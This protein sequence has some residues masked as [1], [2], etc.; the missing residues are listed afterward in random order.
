MSPNA[1]LF[2]AFAVPVVAL[3]QQ[4]ADNNALIER[5]DRLEQ[6]NRVMAEEIH[7]LRLEL[8]KRPPEPSPAPT[9]AEPEMAEQVAVNQQRIT[10]LAEV[11]V[12]AGQKFPVRLTGMALFNAFTNSAP[13][14]GAEN[15]VV[16]P[17]PP[18][19]VTDG[20]TMRQSIVGLEFSGPKMIAG[21]KLS[22]SLYMDFFG[23][24]SATLNHLVRLRTASIQMDWQNT[25]VMFGQQKPIFSPRDPTSLAQV[26]VSPLTAAG[27][28]W[29][30]LPQVRVEQRFSFGEQTQLRAQIGVVQTSEQSA[31][32]DP[33]YAS[34]L[35]PARPA[36]EGRF[37]FK[38]RRGIEIAPGFHV[39]TSHVYGTSVPSNLVQRGLADCTVGQSP[40]HGTL[41]Q[42]REYRQPWHPATGLQDPLPRAR[43]SRCRA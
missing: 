26:A 21:G 4:T 10:D 11:K 32:I 40:V 23:G 7:A 20:A 29:L 28:P 24:T 30:W 33:E 18:G 38:L 39:S 19:T 36:L 12:E 2:V 1:L 9:G 35:A 16:V 6:Q 37:E 22:G 15:P 43:S 25:T 31:S 14:G 42:R 27:N 41:L 17:P 8:A 13:T 3:A 5:L 34:T